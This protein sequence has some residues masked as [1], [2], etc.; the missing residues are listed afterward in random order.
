MTVTGVE[1]LA[2]THIDSVQSFNLYKGSLPRA[3]VFSS[4]SVGSVIYVVALARNL[5]QFTFI[6][7]SSRV[8]AVGFLF[9]VMKNLRPRDHVH[10]GW[11]HPVTHGAHFAEQRQRVYD[12]VLKSKCKASIKV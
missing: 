10:H 3:S 8:L 4:F 5:F 2:K 9:G 6:S 1:H 7:S 12:L 11:C